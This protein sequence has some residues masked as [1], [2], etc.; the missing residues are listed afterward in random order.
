MLTLKQYIVHCDQKH[1]AIGHFNISNL[2]SLKAVFTA[3]SKRQVPF[4][5]GVSEEEIRFIGIKQCVALVRSYRE[6]YNYPIFLNADHVYSFQNAKDVIDAGFDSVIF[7][8][9]R[10]PLGDN[11]RETKKCVDYARSVNPN[12]VVEAELGYIGMPSRFLEAIPDDVHTDKKSFT[13]PDEAAHFVKETGID[14]LAPSVGN[15]HGM[16]KFGKKPELDIDLIKEIREK[17]GIPLVLHGG[18]GI[19]DF[20]FERAIF[21]GISV[22][23]IN[24]ELR[25]AFRKTLFESLKNDPNDLSSS[26]Y[27]ENALFEIEKIVDEK[28]KAFDTHKE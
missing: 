14:C 18:S 26:V 11:I 23:H 17:V 12:I 27:L 10:L 20:I 15:I 13:N 1:S 2:E 3:A 9:V 25:I 16:L 28:L 19:S 4:I 5:V 8:G 24:T 6:E 22:I 7:D 21:A